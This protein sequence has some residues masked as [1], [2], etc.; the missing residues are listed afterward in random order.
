MMLRRTL[1]VVLVHLA[2]ILLIVWIIFPIYWMI[3]VSLKTSEEVF[4]PHYIV[5]NPSPESYVTVLTQGY[6]RVMY[7]W[8]QLL[9]SVYVAALTVLFTLLVS[10]FAGYAL[11]RL[12]FRGKTAISTLTLG[13][14]IPL[15]LPLNTIL[16]T[17][18][19]AQHA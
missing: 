16:H 18:D 9:N 6:F 2:C 19:D 15:R 3:M 4:N 14:Y 17:D 11:S 1:L 13:T 5:T 10:I 12:R 8:R 7:F